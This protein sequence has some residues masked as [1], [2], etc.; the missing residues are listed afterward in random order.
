M[1]LYDKKNTIIFILLVSSLFM[2]SGCERGPKE[3]QEKVLA[4]VGEKTIS[5]NEFI[6]RAEF[7]I[8]PRYC[9]GSH[10]I[11][12]KI[13]LNSLIAE[14]MLALEAG[15]DNDFMRN[16]RFQHYLQGRKEQAMREY[17]Y[18]QEIYRKVKLNPDEI[19]RV[20]RVAGRK[21]QIQ[22]LSLPNDSLTR[23]VDE[24]LAQGRE[25]GQIYQDLTQSDQVPERE[26][27]YLAPEPDVIHQAL[28]SDTLSVGQVI[29]PLRVD[30]N[31]NLFIRIKGWTTRVAL[32]ETDVRQRHQDV[33]EKL[34]AREATVIFENYVTDMMKGKRL[35]FFKDSFVELVKAFAPVYF[36]SE[37]R[38]KDQF[39]AN[40]FDK[41]DSTEKQHLAELDKKISEYKDAPL[42]KIDDQ[43]YTVGD[44][45][46]ELQI[47]PLVFRKKKMQKS[48]FAE[49]FKLAIAD[50]VQDR[51][52]TGQAYQ[53]KYDR[54]PAVHNTVAMWQD[55]LLSMYQKEQYLAT[56]KIDS[57]DEF[58]II[59][60][61]MNPYVDSLQ[62][63]YSDQIEVN[64]AAFDSI[65]LSRIDMM[66]LQ[67][68]VPFPI[69]VPAF[70]QLTTDPWLDYGGKMKPK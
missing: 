12:K 20:Y 58:S 60:K 10:N 16:E 26:I 17:F 59:E 30:H 6:R 32:S 15:K 62:Q 41:S 46:A 64:A 38:Q 19:N 23:I 36:D 35:V 4:R 65:A 8:R 29:G 42:F 70:P 50:M 61:F 2:L 34:T 52:I 43:V 45:E 1:I 47:H 37:Q 5:V 3:P 13:V 68:N 44:F 39:L 49:Q 31:L 22:Y 55:A 27:D 33:V 66:T 57:L 21:Y 28:F 7:T 14:K 53:K 24:K 69:P 48:E 67:Q 25:L 56:T 51:Y 18:Q 11:D 63:K 40:V 54:V 9:S